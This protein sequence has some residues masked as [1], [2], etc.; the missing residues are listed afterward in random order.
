[1]GPSIKYCG[2]VETKDDGN[3]NFRTRFFQ[4]LEELALELTNLKIFQL[5]E[6]VSV[7][8]E[9]NFL[10]LQ[11]IGVSVENEVIMIDTI[12]GLAQDF[13]HFSEDEVNVIGIYS[14]WV[15]GPRRVSISE[16]ATAKKVFIFEMVNL[17]NKEPGALDLCLKAV[18][19]ST[20]ILKLG[21]ALHSDLK[22]L[23]DSYGELECFRYCEAPTL[24]LQK[25]FPSVPG[26]LSDLAKTVLGS[27]LNKSTRMSDWRERPLS[28]SQVH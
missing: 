28:N 23:S 6:P 5:C 14:E 25:V 3:E 10:K 8:G 24:D 2:D 18:F 19:H 22:H 9:A 20:S 17:F 16:I 15:F 1:M 7:E 4:R 11:D 26:G 12:K 21:Y 13:E 27:A